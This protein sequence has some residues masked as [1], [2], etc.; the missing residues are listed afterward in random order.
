[1]SIAKIQN[2][3]IKPTINWY[4]AEVLVSVIIT[5]TRSDFCKS[6]K[7]KKKGLSCLDDIVPNLTVVPKI[8]YDVAY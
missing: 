2:E 3:V 4:F 5:F 8:S 7:K 1:M 6:Q